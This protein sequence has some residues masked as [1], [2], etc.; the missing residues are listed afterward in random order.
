MRQPARSRAAVLIATGR[1]WPVMAA[2]PFELGLDL[3]GWVASQVDQRRLFLLTP[4]ALMAGIILY[5]SAEGEPPLLAPLTG[6]LVAAGLVYFWRRH[7]FWRTLAIGLALVMAGFGAPAL[8]T[9]FAQAPRIERPVFAEVTGLIETVERGPASSRLLVSVQAMS[10]IERSGTHNLDSR[11]R[12]IRVTLRDTML[13]AAGERISFRTRLMPPSPPSLPGGYDFEREAF[14][15][16]IGA[17]GTVAGKVSQLPPEGRIGLHAAIDRGRNILTDR[18]ASVIGGQA[19]ALSAA[20]ITGKRTLLTEQTNDA[21]RAAGIYHIVSI[22]GLHMVLVAGVLFFLV[23]AGLAA[24]PMLALR[25]PIKKIAALVSLL[26]TTAYCIFSGSEVATVRSLIMTGVMLGAI[27]FDRPALSMRNVAIAAILILL[28][29]PE[30]VLGPSFQMSFAAVMALIA[31]HESW[32]GWRAARPPDN[33]QATPG[34]LGRLGR[35]ALRFAAGLA[36]TTL[37]ATAATAPFGI[38]HFQRINSFGLVGNLLAVPLVSFIVMPSAVLGTILYPFGLDR[39]VWTLMGEA[40]AVVI[41]IA[42]RIALWERASL[43]LPAS[44]SGFVL[45]VGA[46][47][48]AAI[49]S[50]R[51]RLLAIVPAFF[52]LILTASVRP[53]DV[54]IASD[55]ASVLISDGAGQGLIFGRNPGEFVLDQ[56]AA[57]A[58]LQAGDIAQASQN[59]GLCDSSACLATLPDGATLSFIAKPDAFEE[60]CRRADIIVTAHQAPG[61]CRPRKLLADKAYLERRGATTI[62][63]QG[64]T[65]DIQSTRNGSEKRPWQGLT[66]IRAW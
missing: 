66:L 29:E 26:G 54:L 55:A 6:L 64:E 15:Q 18:I 48:M 49:P 21:L 65:F 34:M 4:I 17:V 20:L 62:R 7:F 47:L 63:A 9:E 25:W 51:A 45:M 39:F 14:F 40:N 61:W 30:T 35:G 46:L 42:Q 53:P 59:S 43:A 52:G 58:G 60:D 12:H 41:E 1:P 8:R 24:L 56:W 38:E 10:L 28:I 37:V 5:F 16:Q 31:A 13:L 3:S 22:S 33:A 44:G 50:G 11:P 32:S 23:R 19:G 36:A 2:W 27:L 57:S